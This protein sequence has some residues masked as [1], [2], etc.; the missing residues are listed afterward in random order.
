MALQ[1]FCSP[2]G[3]SRVALLCA[4]RGGEGLLCAN[5]G[6]LTGEGRGCCVLIGVC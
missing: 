2:A 1:W 5:R 4:N 6:V 3:S